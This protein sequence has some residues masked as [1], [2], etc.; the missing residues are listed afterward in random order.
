LCKITL[1]SF[2]IL[3]FFC[4]IKIAKKRLLIKKPSARL[5]RW[6]GWEGKGRRKEWFR[7]LNLLYHLEYKIASFFYEKATFFQTKKSIVLFIALMLF[8]HHDTK[9]A[10]SKYG[11]FSENVIKFLQKKHIFSCVSLSSFQIHP[12]K[13][14]LNNVNK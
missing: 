6:A 4:Q 14:P 9:I 10:L 2:A 1:D 5:R 12:Q 13:I 7:K 8:L 11:I 3:I